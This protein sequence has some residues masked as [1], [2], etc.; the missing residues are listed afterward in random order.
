MTVLK[1]RAR[2]TAVQRSHPVTKQVEL[3]GSD[4]ELV[5]LV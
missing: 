1:T 2:T 4:R 3:A 5:N